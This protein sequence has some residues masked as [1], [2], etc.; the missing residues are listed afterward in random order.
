M[1]FGDRNISLALPEL[2]HLVFERRVEEWKNKK[3][4][5]IIANRWRF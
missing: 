3:K 2:V 4:V 5:V 1:V